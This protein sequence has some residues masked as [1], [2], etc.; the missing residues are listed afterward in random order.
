M[1]GSLIMGINVYYLVSGFIKLL[2]NSHLKLG[3]KVFCGILG[4]SGM[5]VYLAGIIYLVLRKNKE[6]SHLLALTTAES[7]QSD[8]GQGD[9]SMFSHPREDIVSMQLP[10]RTRVDLD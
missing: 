6:A 5:A 1:I 8:N 9:A 2:L 7:W 3:A 10:Q 4:F